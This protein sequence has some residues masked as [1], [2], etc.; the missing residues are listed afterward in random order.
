MRWEYKVWA[1]GIR[2]SLSDERLQT[3]LNELGAD[4]WELVAFKGEQFIFKR[5]VG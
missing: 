1:A 5:P 2:A 3:K 4:G